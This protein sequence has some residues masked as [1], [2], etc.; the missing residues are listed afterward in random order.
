MAQL[1][2]YLFTPLLLI[3]QFNAFNVQ[4]DQLVNFRGTKDYYTKILQAA[5]GNQFVK[6]GEDDT[7]IKSIKSVVKNSTKESENKLNLVF[8]EQLKF[9]AQLIEIWNPSI[10]EK[11]AK[12]LMVELKKLTGKSTSKEPAKKEV[13][14]SIKPA[15]LD[16]L[17]ALYKQLDSKT[18]E[19]TLLELCTKLLEWQRTRKVDKVYAILEDVNKS[20]VG[21]LKQFL[22]GYI[23]TDA[24]KQ[25]NILAKLA[26]EESKYYYKWQ[27][28]IGVPI[29]DGEEEILTQL[30]RVSAA[31][32]S[33]I[34]DLKQGKQAS[35]YGNFLNQVF[36]ECGRGTYKKAQA[37]DSDNFLP[38]A[39]TKDACFENGM[40]GSY[41][42]VYIN[43]D[44]KSL[45]LDVDEETKTYQYTK[46]KGT[47]KKQFT[48][49]YDP[50]HSLDNPTTNDDVIYDI[51][52]DK[53]YLVAL[54]TFINALPQANGAGKSTTV[55]TTK[56]NGTTKKIYNS[57]EAILTRIK[58][59][60]DKEKIIND[61]KSFA[62]NEA[63]LLPKGNK[64]F[65]YNDTDVL[66]SFLSSV[67][68]GEGRETS[69]GYAMRADKV[70]EVDYR[71]SFATTELTWLPYA[72]LMAYYM[73]LDSTSYRKEV[74]EENL[75][76]EKFFPTNWP[77][78]KK[79]RSN[80]EKRTPH[81]SNSWF[82]YHKKFKSDTN[83]Q[84]RN[85]PISNPHQ[86][87]TMNVSIIEQLK[88]ESKLKEE[89]IIQSEKKMDEDITMEDRLSSPLTNIITPTKAIKTESSFFTEAIKPVFKRENLYL[90]LWKKGDDFENE[91]LGESKSERVNA[92]SVM[93]S[94]LKG[95]PIYEEMKNN[96]DNLKITASSLPATAFAKYI[97]GHNEKAKKQWAQDNGI[98]QAADGSIDTSN[99][100]SN[101]VRTDQEWCHL[102]G[103]G[104]GGTE[105]L[106]NFVSGSKHCN[107]EQLAI[108]TGQRRITHK[109]ELFDE[110]TKKK[111]T[112]RISA[113]L[114]PNYSIGIAGNYTLNEIKEKL[115]AGKIPIKNELLQAVILGDPI[116]RTSPIGKHIESNNKLNSVVDKTD[117]SVYKSILTYIIENFFDK[118][119]TKFNVYILKKEP[120]QLEKAFAGL[121]EKVQLVKNYKKGDKDANITAM[122]KAARTLLKNVEAN[123]FL[124][125]PLAR[126]IRYKIYYDNKKVFDHIFDAQS[127]CLDYNECQILD[128]TVER[129]L[130]MATGKEKEYKQLIKER[131]KNRIPNETE[132]KF[133][134]E[135][136][137]VIDGLDQEIKRL[138]QRIREEQR[139]YNALPQGITDL[140]TFKKTIGEIKNEL[141]KIIKSIEETHKTY[142][143]EMSKLSILPSSKIPMPAK[144]IDSLEKQLKFLNEGKN[145]LLQTYRNI[146][147]ESL[148][149]KFLNKNQPKKRARDEDD[150]D[151]GEGDTKKRKMENTD[152]G[153]L[154]ED[155]G[156]YFLSFS[157]HTSQ[158][159]T[160]EK[161][162]EED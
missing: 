45:Y 67:N 73:G 17:K 155:L 33:R 83:I 52:T 105:E 125:L 77:T 43:P 37:S 120:A 9:N 110:K 69:S 152:I 161:D 23:K 158:D 21:T 100:S 15:D 49:K 131:I 19:K 109:K 16:K 54:R 101:S 6:K 80:L 76:Q 70:D 114:M 38:I 142:Q 97:L 41:F 144:M 133:I 82:T 113:Y 108:E 94:A 104:D 5:Y 151:K 122:K 65:Y 135:V 119:S 12:Q 111:I 146:E 126:W 59:G 14:I 57:E 68:I 75:K 10:A 134:E 160:M 20:L 89:G 154:P 25:K 56:P 99:I 148:A 48:Y 63:Q 47:Y 150:G 132:Y 102:L 1:I 87:R 85:K 92:A 7:L 34:Y 55:Y 35:Q 61:A 74:H 140:G 78:S 81:Y 22:I 8:A 157:I 51:G 66:K 127:E 60:T 40:N 46:E 159:Q 112:A 116:K 72:H 93:A 149:E 24:L 88:K 39:I 115:E 139:K 124:Y 50:N 32:H 29:K 79:Y 71:W 129:A 123:F 128:Y 162:E 58:E 107:T 44:A 137:G 26:E 138:S 36:G 3:A 53:R 103:H 84:R 86:T 11:Q 147:A 143:T 117:P 18:E 153:F 141:D 145:N 96:K 27:E 90:R 62:E 30:K 28:E 31:T 106:G 2:T 98:K 91:L 42:G 13:E 118:D 64:C 136:L 95:F 156:G 4:N 130:Y 121:K